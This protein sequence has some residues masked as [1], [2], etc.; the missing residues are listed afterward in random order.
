[1]TMQN[2]WLR[3]ASGFLPV[4]SVLQ[5]RL[6]IMLNLGFLLG[7]LCLFPPQSFAATTLLPFGSDWYYFDDGYLPAGN[8]AQYGYDDSDWK[9]GTARF[10]YGDGDETTLVN[11]GPDDEHKFITTYFRTYVYIANPAQYAS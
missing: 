4:C 10:G 8:W 6:G 7:C 2:F 11:Y 9:Y 5:R 1:M 3:F